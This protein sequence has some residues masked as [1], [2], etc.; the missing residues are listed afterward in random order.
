MDKKN[1][2]SCNK[3]GNPIQGRLD[4][5]FCDAYCRNSF[6][7]TIKRKNEQSILEVNRAL[8]KNRTILKTLS[9]V[10]KSTVRKEVLDAMGYNFNVFSS[11]YRASKSNIYYL[12]Y[13][14]GFSPIV[15]SK[16]VEQAVIIHKQSYMGDWKPWKY[17]H[18]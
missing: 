2:P 12:C 8:R 18:T 1:L 11:M 5:K 4:K 16:G 6:N 7:N 9:P 17:V 14:Y 15:D 10:G 3:C 13:E